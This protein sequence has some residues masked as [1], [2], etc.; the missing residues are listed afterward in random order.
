MGLIPLTAS[1]D[2]A[3]ALDEAKKNAD[4]D[5]LTDVTVDFSRGYYILFSNQCVRVSGMG[6]PRE[7]LQGFLEN[8]RIY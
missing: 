8:R 5:V 3:Q 4:V 7:R 6:V 1:P 2:T